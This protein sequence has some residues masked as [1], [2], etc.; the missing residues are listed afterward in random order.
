MN[1]VNL[2]GRITRDLELRQ[3]TS[4]QI[5]CEFSLAVNRTRQEG[6]DF[7]NVT[8]WGKQAE[9]LTKY[10]SKGSLI[11]VSGSLRVDKYE[12]K[13]GEKRNR[14]YVLANSIEYLSNK[15]SETVNNTTVIETKEENDPFQYYQDTITIDDSFLD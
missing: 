13:E 9:N 3:T 12:T 2:I 5:V 8:V 4:G 10:Q 1:N 6:A 11:A 7:I 14:V 15:S